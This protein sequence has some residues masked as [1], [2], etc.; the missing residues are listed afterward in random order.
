MNPAL[1]RRMRIEPGV[2]VAI[3][4]RRACIVQVLDL[5]TVVVR[6]PDEGKAWHAKIEDLRPADSILEAPTEVAFTEL[7]DI[8]GPAGGTLR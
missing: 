6:D 4:G 8:E 1:T 5:E 3:K 7:T 2:W